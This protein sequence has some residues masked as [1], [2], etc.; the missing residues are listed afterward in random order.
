MDRWNEDKV[1]QTGRELWLADW[2]RSVAA[3]YVEVRDIAAHD[4][5]AAWERWRAEREA[6]TGAIPSPPSPR[7]RAT[8]SEPATGRTTIGPLDR[9]RCRRDT[10]PAMGGIG[11]IGGLAI[12]LPNS[13]ADTLAFDRVGRVELPHPAGPA[14]LDLYW[15]R[16]Y[17]GGLFL[18]FL[19]ATSGRETVRRGPLPARHREGRGP[20]RRPGAGTLVIDLNFAYHPSCA[21]DPNWACPLAPPGNRLAGARGGRRAA[22]LTSRWVPWRS[23]PTPTR[24]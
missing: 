12:A 13:G 9:R 6:L 20:R 2:R 21:F 7:T 5:A 1:A 16:G 14:S 18:P 24:R 22:P 17:A 10:T 11:G 8:P 3:L 4:P 23:C 15:M 19:D